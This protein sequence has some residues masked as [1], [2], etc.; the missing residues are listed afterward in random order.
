MEYGKLYFLFYIIGLCSLTVIS[1][2][3]FKPEILRYI[4]M[5]NTIIIMGYFLIIIYYE[6]QE[7]V[8]AKNIR[9]GGLISRNKTEAQESF[10]GEW[11][12]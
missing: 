8:S 12:Q 3:I 4:I 10:M 7:R 2:F 1:F 9:I 5:Y 6:I 11:E